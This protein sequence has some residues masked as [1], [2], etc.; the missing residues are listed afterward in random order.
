MFVE[1]GM[2]DQAWTRREW[3]MLIGLLLVSL[4]LRVTGLDRVPPGVRYDELM[5]M[6]MVDRV[7]AGE[8][9]VYFQESW[10]HEPLYHYVQ[11]GVI[12]LWGRTAVGLRLPSALM[13][14]ASVLTA[15]LAVRQLFGKKVAFVSAALLGVSLWSLLHSRFGLRIIGVM[16]WLG[17][18]IYAFWRGLHVPRERSGWLWFVLC[19]LCQGAMLYTYFAGWVA[20]AFFV[21]LAL[22]L[23]LFHRPMLRRRWPGLVLALLLPLL[24]YAPLAV[25]L[26]RHPE[27]GAR[28]GQVGSRLREVVEKGD[29]KPLLRS[30]WE[31]LLMFSFKG[32]PEWLYNIS[33]RPIFDPATSILFYGGLL[34]ALWRWRDA[35]YGMLLLWLGAGIV[36]AM[37]AWPAGSLSHSIIAQP[38]VF[39]F[40]A[41]FVAEAWRW[42]ARR[43]RSWRRWVGGLAVA[44][45]VLFGIINV[46]D[47]AVRWP[48]AEMVR[49][50]YQAPIAAVA[51][52]L[53]K[54]PETTPVYVSAPFVDYWNPWSKAAFD[55]LYTRR[56]VPVSWFNGEAAILFPAEGSLD[57]GPARYLLPDHVRWPSELDPELF[58]LLLQGAVPLEVGHEEWPGSRFDVYAW[59]D[60]A[61]LDAYL[62]ECA[63]APVWASPEGPYEE[64][65]SE[66]QRW[67]VSLPLDFGD[68]LSLLGYRFDRSRVAPTGV[69][70]MITCWRVLD[71]NS[72]PLAIFVH[73]LDD[74]NTV[75][76]SQDVLRVSTHWQPGDIIIHV[77]ELF[78][79]AQVP[80]GTYRAELGVYSPVTMDRLPLFDQD[81][82]SIPHHRLLLQPLYVE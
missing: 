77:H 6:R 78:V 21:L 28:A 48:A 34:I 38:A 18:A 19:G 20:W 66:E 71:A 35:R 80:P 8:W 9:P 76:V 24:L 27:L 82:V 63:S 72:D 52:Y 17:L 45:L 13:G 30:A 50:E 5:N 64:G 1:E 44:T 22:Y 37:I 53:E 67:A 54:Q 7:L 61:P 65:I 31:T 42:A 57:L 16:P 25:Y 51:R 3:V 73:A 10:G 68:R 46:Y 43:G 47:Y 11:A 15:Y 36:P 59:Q 56:D 4:C 33:G 62:T 14:T 81:Q 55:L 23:A 58:D 26:A 79:F 41:I 32:D 40:P 75:R 69:W 29:V 60:R 39:G 2:Q 70:R 12:A 74:E 49:H